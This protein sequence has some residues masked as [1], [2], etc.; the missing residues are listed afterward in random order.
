MDLYEYVNSW[1]H[2][3]R[4]V[5]VNSG[6]A[7]HVWYTVGGFFKNYW[8][9]IGGAGETIGW[10]MG[11]GLPSEYLKIVNHLRAYLLSPGVTV[12]FHVL[13][14]EMSRY[15]GRWWYLMWH[16]LVQV[17]KLLQTEWCV[18]RVGS[19]AWS[20]IPGRWFPWGSPTS[21]RWVPRGYRKG[22][23]YLVTLSII[24]DHVPIEQIPLSSW[25]Y[26]NFSWITLCNVWVLWTMM[27]L[28]MTWNS[29]ST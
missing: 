13:P 7:P 12:I 20:L 14:W 23:E 26:R 27:I 11:T 25:R 3:R 24:M 1:N 15:F 2:I 21:R 5:L 29:T 8:R 28:D 22:H 18:G 9:L 19:G 4:G 16:E 6:L 10:G 17:P